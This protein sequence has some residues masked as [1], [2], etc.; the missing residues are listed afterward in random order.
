MA[1]RWYIGRAAF[2][3]L[4]NTV[5]SGAM[6][7]TAEVL[8]SHQAEGVSCMGRKY[9][10]APFKK[11]GGCQNNIVW[12]LKDLWFIFEGLSFYFVF[13]VFICLRLWMTEEPRN[14]FKLW[15]LCH[16]ISQTEGTIHLCSPSKW[17]HYVTEVLQAWGERALRE[18]IVSFPVF[19]GKWHY[20]QRIILC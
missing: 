14:D 3:S 1:V 20:F 2:Q 10:E 16:K 8:N 18:L 12:S 11:E 15:V 7:S 17:G 4:W 9:T 19:G 5:N 6:A 13:T